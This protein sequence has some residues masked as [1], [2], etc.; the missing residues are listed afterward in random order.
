MSTLGDC[1]NQVIEYSGGT[2]YPSGNGIY[3]Y[4]NPWPQ[5]YWPQPVVVDR[6]YPVYVPQP[7]ISACLHCFCK[8]D[9]DNHLRCCKCIERLHRDFVERKGR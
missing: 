8:D 7:V 9:D 5:P 2:V 3:P 4:W 6:P 1:T